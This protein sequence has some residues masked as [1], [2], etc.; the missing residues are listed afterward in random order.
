MPPDE[1]NNRDFDDF[2]CFWWPKTSNNVWTAKRI[3]LHFVTF[4]L[5]FVFGPEMFLHLTDLF[6]FDGVFCRFR[7]KKMFWHLTDLF[8]VQ[9]KMCL[10]LT[11]FL[12]F[13]FEGQ[14]HTHERVWGVCPEVVPKRVLGVWLPHVPQVHFWE[15]AIGVEWLENQKSDRGKR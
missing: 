8:V 13:L 3:P 4:L 2:C 10:H 6:A 12:L 9:K 7:F 14:E 15:P 5:I 1:E 11:E